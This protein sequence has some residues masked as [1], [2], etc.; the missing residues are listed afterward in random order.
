MPYVHTLPI[1]ENILLPIPN[2]KPSVLPSKAHDV[3]EFAN[4]V[5]G[6]NIPAFEI[7]A[8]LSKTPRQVNIKAI[9]IKV[10]L[11]KVIERLSSI[12]NIK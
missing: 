9:K 12:K 3:I 11:T 6:I 10:A 5:I 1:K 7:I 2:I 4:P 8:N